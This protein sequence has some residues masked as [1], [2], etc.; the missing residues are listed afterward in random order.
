MTILFAASEMVPFCKTGGLADVIGALPAELAKMGHDVSVMLPGYSAIDRKRFKFT[1][2]KRNLKVKVGWETKPLVVSSASIKRVTIYLLENEE[3]FG[4]ECLYCDDK[5][6]YGD[7]GAR[8]IFYSSGV[9][10]TA[11][12]LGIKPDI[13]HAHD[14]QAGMVIAYLSTVYAEDPWFKGTATLFTIHNLGYQGIFP[15][16]VFSLTNISRAE[17]NWKKMEYWGNLSFLKSGIVY[18]DAVSTVSERYAAEITTKPLGFGMNGVLAERRYDLYG[19]LN[20]IDQSEW[21]PSTDKSIPAVYDISDMKG[22]KTCRKKLLDECGLKAKENVPIFG[23]VTRLDD[24]KGLDILHEAMGRLTSMDIRMVILGAGSAEHQKRTRE[25]SERHIDRL[26]VT[27][28]FDSKMARNIYAGSD[29]FIMPSRYEP[30]GLGQLIAMKYGTLPVVH[31]T[32]GLAD[33]VNDIDLNHEKGNGFSF[34]EYSSEALV[35]T[36]ARAVKTFRVPGR[37]LWG[38]AVRHAMTND[39]SW[40]KSAKK[41]IDL[42]NEIGNRKKI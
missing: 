29:A 38:K 31:A 12:V 14:W 7:N 8:F 32:G 11:K 22:K 2:I 1:K 20:G 27:I 23:M 37:A 4:R 36:V 40:E 16:Y 42:Y 25:L 3:Y 28:G 5:G 26:H 18:A 10:E 34:N 9:I 13:V 19:I 15:Q 30:C 6:D 35:E 33:T 24:Q 39:F 41:Y 17:F 21:D